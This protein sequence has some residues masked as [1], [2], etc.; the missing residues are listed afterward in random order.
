MDYEMRLMFTPDVPGEFCSHIAYHLATWLS[1]ASHA[2]PGRDVEIVLKGSSCDEAK[3]FLLDIC[4]FLPMDVFADVRVNGWSWKKAASQLVVP[5][6]RPRRSRE[7]KRREKCEFAI[8]QYLI[9]S[10]VRVERATVPE[11]GCNFR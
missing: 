11:P 6:L 2:K 5:E 4:H 1:R 7:A 8:A 9:N 3:Q 10:G